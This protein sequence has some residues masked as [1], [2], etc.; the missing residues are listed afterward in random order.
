MGSIQV[1]GLTRR[2]PSHRRCP[3]R[4]GEPRSRGHGVRVH[5]L[6]NLYVYFWRWATWK[7]FD[8]D[9]NATTGVVCF[10]TVIEGV[11]PDEA[12]APLRRATELNLNRTVQLGGHDSSKMLQL[13]G[14]LRRI[15][16]ADGSVVRLGY[17]D[18]NGHPYRSMGRFLVERREI[19]RRRIADGG[20]RFVSI[21]A[22]DIATGKVIG[23]CLARHRA[24]EFLAFLKKIEN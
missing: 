24:D 16:F 9:P 18:Q 5:N 8:H 6:Y 4:L 14:Q 11:K 10:I 7:V 15:E 17:A 12:L 19:V 1:G 3:D 20:H 21:P 23:E 2:D 13:S 22:L